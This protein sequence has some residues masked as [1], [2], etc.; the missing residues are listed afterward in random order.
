MSRLDLKKTLK[1]VY[2]PSATEPALVTVP[3]FA[4]FMLDGAGDPN[5][6]PAFEAATQALYGL[7]YALK[8]ALKKSGGEDYTVMPLEGLWWCPDM[9]RFDVDDKSKWLWTLLIV[10]PMPPSAEEFAALQVQ[11]EQRK[12]LPEVACVRMERLSEG[13][14]AQIMHLGPYAAECETIARLHT[15]IADSGHE[16]AGKHHEIYLG[17]PRRIAPEKLK[18]VIRQPVR[19]K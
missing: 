9:A 12:G 5:D 14:C 15:F 2:Q 6:N 8:F 18:T 19:A 3:E 13:L 10:Q 16:C 7:S 1:D 4:C 11:T 17:D